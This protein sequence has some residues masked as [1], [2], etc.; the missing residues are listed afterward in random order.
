MT[1]VTIARA[2]WT[3]SAAGYICLLSRPA[4]RPG[5]GTHAEVQEGQRECRR[6]EHLANSGLTTSMTMIF[7]NGRSAADHGKHQE[8]QSS[9]FQPEHV[10]HMAHTGQSHPTSLV[11]SSYPA[12]LARFAARNAQK[13]PALSTEIA[14]RHA[15]FTFP[16]A[17]LPRVSPCPGSSFYQRI[18]AIRATVAGKCALQSQNS[19]SSSGIQIK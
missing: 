5:E 8:Q 18:S 10:Q 19:G 1:R 7:P 15:S 14:G 9:N 2:A 12:I 17:L 11:S 6:Q 16:F 4:A 13:C 3:N